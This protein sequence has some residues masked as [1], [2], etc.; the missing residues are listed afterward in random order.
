MR[1]IRANLVLWLVSAL[2]LGTIV[3]L[4]ATYVLT[5]NQIGRV[6]D[7]ELKQVAHAVHLREDWQTRRVRIARPGFALSVRA[8]DQGGRIYFET[9]LPSLP[10]DLPQTYTEGYAFMDSAEGLWRVYTHVTEEGTVQVGQA[11]GARD[12]L[13]RDLSISVLMPMLMLIP[14]LVVLVA[15]VLKRGLAPLDETSRRV[16]DRDASRLDPLPTDNVP[17]ELLP[18]VEQINALLARLEGA[19]GAQRRFLA[20]AAHELRS[21]VAALALQVQLA[22]RA[23]S[24]AARA[25]ALAELE[26]GVERARRLVQQLMDFARLEPG[27]QS[28][29]FQPV[30]LARMAREVVGSYAPRAES[31]EVDLGADAPASAWIPGAETELRSLLENLVDNALRYAPEN[32]AVTVSV[33]AEE[34]QVELCVTDAG[35][36]IPVT[37]RE[38]VFERF[39]RVA[40]DSTRGTGLGLA[41]VKAIAERHQGTIA[42]A[43]S[44]PGAALPGLA[45]RIRFPARLPPGRRPEAQANNTEPLAQPAPEI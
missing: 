15:W 32:S 26:R 7:D 22:E 37:E 27:V 18:L 38:R 14:L 8:Y 45:V 6:F 10:S 35:R 41:I 21:P 36:G 4:A 23:H 9:A 34:R 5:R 3:V 2:A 42:L 40:G 1:S 11:M 17:R 13:A 29:P 12:T 19:L 24:T 44:Q 31:Q 25:T 43:D 33:R 28:A 30:N 16:S 20:D 39:H